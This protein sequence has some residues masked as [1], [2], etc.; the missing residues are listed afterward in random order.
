MR[1]RYTTIAFAYGLVVLA[2]LAFGWLSFSRF[3]S[4]S[5]AM[6]E[7][8]RKHDD[9]VIS[10]AR[11][12][13][14]SDRTGLLVR[15][16]LLGGDSSLLKQ[17]NETDLEFDGHFRALQLALDDARSLQLLQDLS[18]AKQA[19]R[20]MGRVFPLRGTT[21]ADR[22]DLVRSTEA[23][24][25]ELQERVSHLQDAL[26][27][28]ERD[29][30][31]SAKD[32]ALAQTVRARRELAALASVGL[33]ILLLSTVVLVQTMRQL[34]RSR[35]ELERVNRDLDEFGGRVAHDLRNLL[36]PVGLAASSLDRSADRAEIV[37][38]IAGR[39]KGLTRRSNDLIESLLAFAH[40]GQPAD[41]N[42][43][44]DVGQVVRDAVEDLEANA[45]AVDARIEVDTVAAEVSCSPS[46]LHTVLVNVIGNALKFLD[47][48][49]ERAV[50]ITSSRMGRDCEIA[51][52]DTGSGIPKDALGK[53]WTPFYR[54]PGTRAPGHGIG[55]ATVSRI[56]EAH[57][58]SIT[59]ESD[60]THGSTFRLRLPLRQPATV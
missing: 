59:V 47:G 4:I 21:L 26:A 1:P 30:L 52:A 60:G 6:W 23:R 5:N 37:R 33:A 40:S 48:R 3:E 2:G 27:T 43:V 46:L 22:A 35:D 38:T 17:A 15:E 8:M 58:G 44:S 51:I 57:H 24:A 31:Q 20:G 7:V 25:R 16:Y 53:L 42:A 39:L 36:A 55:L 9:A 45:R 32:A 13:D 14:A 29:L 50:R 56:L 49:P 28:H 54:V 10:I 34:R 18:V 11:L 19:Q 41:A 12:Q